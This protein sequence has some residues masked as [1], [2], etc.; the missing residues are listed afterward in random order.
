MKNANF[1]TQILTNFTVNASNGF[2]QDCIL[3]NIGL[4]KFIPSLAYSSF[5]AARK[6]K[7]IRFLNS[8]L[9]VCQL[10]KSEIYWD[11]LTAQYKCAYLLLQ[12]STIWLHAIVSEW[13]V[14]VIKLPHFYENH[15]VVCVQILYIHLVFQCI[16]FLVRIILWLTYYF[17]I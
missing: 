11:P 4:D 6:S 2:R 7:R 12:L 13:A 10:C 15:A 14:N 1:E 3:L 9:C 16:I 17:W 5:L 8:F